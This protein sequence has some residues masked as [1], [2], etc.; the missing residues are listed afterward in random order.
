LLQIRSIILRGKDV[1]DAVVTFE[2]GANILAGASDTGKSYL[3]HCLDY[4]LGADE[5]KKR[6]DEAEPYSQLFVEFGNTKAEFL[7]LERSLGGGNLIAHKGRLAAID[8]G[9]GE[10]IAPKRAGKSKAKDVTE[11]LFAFA[12][13]KEAK[14]RKNDRGEINRLT[15]RTIL[16]LFLVDEVSVIDERSPVLGRT[17]FD[18]TAR[19]RSFAY[20][21][22]GR[23][24]EGI[25]ASEKREITNA[26]LNA[27]LSIISDLL[28]PIEKRL[29]NRAI[30]NADEAIRHVD[31]A[32]ASVSK[33]LSDHSAERAELETQ[34]EHAIEAVQRAESQLVAIDELLKQY[35]L[36]DDRY[37]TDLDRLDFIS[38]GAHFF[39]GL[40][41]VRCPL[42]DQVMGAAHAHKASE[43]SATVYQ[44]ARAE[45]SKILAHRSDLSEATTALM[46]VRSTREAE[47]H[48][49]RETITLVNARVQSILAPEMQDGSS[50]LDRL[51]TRRLELETTRSD[52]AQAFD[53]RTLKEQIERASR[54]EKPSS[55]GW[56]PLPAA[57]LRKFCTEVE[58]VLE[59]WGWEG[60]GRVEF[61]EAE[62]DI[63]VDGQR[64]QSHG[65]GVR[66]ILYSAFVVGLL[67]YCQAN[68]R[69]HLGT[70]VIDSPLTSYKK[71]KIGSATDGPVDAGIEAAFWR[72]LSNASLGAQLIIIENKEPPTDVAQ[73]VHYEWF[74]GRSAQRGERVGFIPSPTR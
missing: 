49:A 62:Y 39:E 50:R 12:G 70:V 63:K 54:G 44:A 11:V 35:G 60:E 43:R 24:D 19:R 64:R 8:A 52:E 23:D 17:G 6:I 14:L 32:I 2:K 36:L 65:K 57:S 69:P 73:Q 37:R 20:M 26:R 21:L 48:D 31:Q 9:V 67:R 28:I 25:I 16:P 53:L 34:R 68:G 42:C 61:D 74:A 7:T 5:M 41:E 10:S 56:E 72:S 71:G 47:R 51:V 15:I 38:E 33:A 59:E 27:Q 4:I 30:E 3:V 13:I 29:Q 46:K 45:A 1:E 58:N 18:A 66:A 40:Q 55:K 22:S